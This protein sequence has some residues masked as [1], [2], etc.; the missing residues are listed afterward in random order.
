MARNQIVIKTKLKGQS[1][2]RVN[3][4][5]THET[6]NVAP[7]LKEIGDSLV[8]LNPNADIDVSFYVFNSIS[9]TWME[10]VVYYANESRI[11]NL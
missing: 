5:V 10:M 4:D 9:D 2:Q 8:A 1:T 11:V 6:E 7:V 3:I